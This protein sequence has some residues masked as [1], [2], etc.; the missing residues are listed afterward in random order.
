LECAC[1]PQ[2]VVQA[3]LK[4]ALPHSY[5]LWP[6]ACLSLRRRRVGFS[7]TAWFPVATWAVGEKL[8][9]IASTLAVSIV[10]GAV[11]CKFAPHPRRLPAAS[12]LLECGC[13][14]SVRDSQG[15]ATAARPARALRPDHKVTSPRDALPGPGP[16]GS[17]LVTTLRLLSRFLE[18]MGQ[19]VLRVRQR[20]AVWQ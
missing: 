17:T 4:S 9:A 1:F 14:V 7:R 13:N 20:P 2:Q 5:A 15:S 3:R 18:A 11:H 16:I 12:R 6:A 8:L 10:P 19:D